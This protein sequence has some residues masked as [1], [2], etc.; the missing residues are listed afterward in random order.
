[1]VVRVFSYWPDLQI[2]NISQKFNVRTK[3]HVLQYMQHHSEFADRLSWL[4]GW[5]GLTALSA[6]IGHIVP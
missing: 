3:F 5:L 1:M 4:V 6:Q 2:F